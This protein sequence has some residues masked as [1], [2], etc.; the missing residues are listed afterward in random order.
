MM[1]GFIETATG[2]AVSRQ[3]I[4]CAPQ[5]IHLLGKSVIHQGAMV[6]G[7]LANVSVFVSCCV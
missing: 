2:N 7:D 3:S 5:N 6:R 4:L 1:N